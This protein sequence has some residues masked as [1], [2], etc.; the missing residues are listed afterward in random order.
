MLGSA[1]PWYGRGLGSTPGAGF[2]DTAEAVGYFLLQG[3]AVHPP[4]IFRCPTIRRW[5]SRRSVPSSGTQRVQLPH[6]SV[7]F[8]AANHSWR[9]SS[10]SISSIRYPSGSSPDGR[11]F[12]P[13]VMSGQRDCP[14]TGPASIISRSPPLM[15][16]S[17]SWSVPSLVERQLRVRV[18]GADRPLWCNWQHSISRSGDFPT[19]TCPCSSARNEHRPSKPG[20][21]GS[22]PVRDVPPLAVSGF[23]RRLLRRR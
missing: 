21:T 6:R 2:R 7:D 18:P 3:A 15:R 23:R 10:R 17:S 16:W 14:D 20:V 9:P 11:P 19:T 8:P 12:R 4:P 5:P 1:R 13:I 22:N